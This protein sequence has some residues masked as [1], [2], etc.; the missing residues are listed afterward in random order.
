MSDRVKGVARRK[1]FGNQGIECADCEK[2]MES[3]L[4]SM[5]T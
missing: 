1:G 3:T 4:K 2:G 5:K